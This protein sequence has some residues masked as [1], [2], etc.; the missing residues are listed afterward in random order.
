[1][2]LCTPMYM[3]TYL[4]ISMYVGMQLDKYTYLPVCL[5]VSLCLCACLPACLPVSSSTCASVGMYACT[6]VGRNHAWM[7]G[8]KRACVSVRMHAF[9]HAWMNECILS[10]H[11][12]R[13]VRVWVYVGMTACLYPRAH[14]AR[15]LCGCVFLGNP[16]HCSVFCYPLK[17]KKKGTITNRHT[18][19][20]AN[21]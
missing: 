20:S 12:C 16:K 2:C 1:M 17:T 6:H 13:H 4:Y 10:L 15:Y 19:V 18:H 11:A 9:N 7:N 3:Y 14:V 21:A 8:W 5:A